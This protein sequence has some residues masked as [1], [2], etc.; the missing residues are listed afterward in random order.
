L[1]LPLSFTFKQTF[2]TLDFRFV[3]SLRY[4]KNFGIP[5]W[6]KLQWY[7]TV[8]IGISINNLM[9]FVGTLT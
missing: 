4:Q 1:K 7:I 8:F 2:D 6:L 3:Y 5:S 9:P